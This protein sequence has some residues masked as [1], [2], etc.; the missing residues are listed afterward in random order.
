M[1]RIL[2]VDDDDQLSEL[3]TEWLTE[4]HFEVE[5]A[6]SGEQAE[7]MLNGRSY[8]LIVLDWELPD[9]T[10]IEILK[11]LRA[12]EKSTPILMLTGRDSI[13]NKEQGLDS[14]ADDYL[15]KPFHMKELTARIRAL[16][17]RVT[18]YSN[19]LEAGNVSVDPKQ[20]TVSVG[21]KPVELV[22]REF[23]LLEYLLRHKGQIFSST[24]L[25]DSVWTAESDVGPETVRQCVKRLRQ[26]ID[27]EGQ[28]SLIENVFKVGYR[29]RASE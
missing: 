18:P 10:G 28:E 15:T 17:R 25:I 2:V 24:A 3:I 21:G 23:A 19:L 29:I 22:H 9:T 27:T 16:L 11:Q 26:K 5:T 12:A 20:R 13:S 1:S 4:E 6:T 14:G 8:D 7:E